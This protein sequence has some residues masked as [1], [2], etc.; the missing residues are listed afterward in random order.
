[1]VTAPADTVSLHAIVQS[2]GL[3]WVES[4]PGI[5]HAFATQVIAQAK[6]GREPKAAELVSDVPLTQVETK[7]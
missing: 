2:A 6:L 5:A 3:Q 7:K 1:M 4:K